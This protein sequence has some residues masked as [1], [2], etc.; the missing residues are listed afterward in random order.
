MQHE[1]AVPKAEHL[2]PQV[3][4]DRHVTPQQRAESSE[5]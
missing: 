4:G 1:I 2:D 5:A 3:F